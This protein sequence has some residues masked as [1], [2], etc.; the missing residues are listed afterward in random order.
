M[1]E[2]RNH[3]LAINMMDGNCEL[4]CRSDPMEDDR[5]QV[6][7][8]TGFAQA[9]ALA[10][11]LLDAGAQPGPFDRLAWFE[12][13]HASAFPGARP[14]ILQA[15]G[16]GEAR[17]WLFLAREKPGHLTGIANW[18]SFTYRPQFHGAPDAATKRALLAAIARALRGHGSRLRLHP[19]VDDETADAA[20][21][22]A[23][24]RE[25]GWHVVTRAMSRK[26]LL[27]LPPGTSFA[28]YW[29]ERPG[30][31]RSTFRRKQQQH[32]LTLRIHDTLDDALWSTF[33][34]IF[35]RSW[36]PD[37]DDFAFLRAF[38]ETEAAA[39]QLRL[40]I[41]HGESGPSAVELWTVDQG[42]AYI[43]K[44]AFDERF[45]D[46]SPGTQLSHAMFRHAIDM[47]KVRCIDFGTGDND[48]KANWMPRS[49]PMRQIDAFDLARPT[50]WRGAMMA[51]LSA[52]A[53]P[54]ERGTSRKADRGRRAALAAVPEQ[55]DR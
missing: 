33:E 11:G 16:P 29:A 32:P 15:R 1:V 6:E 37:G 41:G 28:D 25:G 51:H 43:H 36:K 7:C 54:D 4:V 53:Q 20:L 47:D 45:A 26:R 39:G 3:V 21:I 52:I 49:V 55:G 10:E 34:Q 18:Y 17:A 27:H 8:S 50:S 14:F 31:L 5:I 12:A 23:A 2:W 35:A 38:A 48:Y 46:H 42:T 19:I 30:A 44:L 9:R 22:A 13:L 40:G 24:F